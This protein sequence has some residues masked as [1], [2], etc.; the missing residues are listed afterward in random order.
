M[1]VLS[2]GLVLCATLLVLLATGLT[3]MSPGWWRS[4]RADDPRTVA[5]A[6]AIEN[7]LVNEMYQVRHEKATQWSVGLRAADANAWLN[8]R[9]SQWIVNRDDSFTWPEQVSNVQVEFDRGLVHVGLEFVRDERPQVLSATLRPEFHDDGSLW[10]RAESVTIGRL[11][12][13]ADWFLEQAQSSSADLLPAR[14]MQ[15]PETQ[16]LFA[17]LA[18]TGPLASDPLVHLGDGR[19]V[20]VLALHASGSTL[21]LTLQTEYED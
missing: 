7:D 1:V 16:R 15:H 14:V 19:R 10:V 5:L 9:L 12:L 3:R 17:A 21:H 13:P 11:P 8:T 4:V 6:E 2:I 20:R 18:G